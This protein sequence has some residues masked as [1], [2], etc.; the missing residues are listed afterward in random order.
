M[1]YDT[2]G[3]RVPAVIVSPYG[4]PDFV[5]SDVFD[6]TSVLKLLQ[7]KWNLP[8]L[9]HRDAAASSPLGALDLS[10]RPAF[11][12]PPQLPDPRLEWGTGSGPRGPVTLSACARSGVQGLKHNIQGRNPCH[13]K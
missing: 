12:D 7:E 2:Y 6:H 11:L 13:C 5:L 9:T 1:Q 3:F 8:S 4:R 10:A